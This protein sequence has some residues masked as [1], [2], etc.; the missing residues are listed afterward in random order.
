MHKVAEFGA[1][2]SCIHSINEINM[3]QFEFVPS[4]IVIMLIVIA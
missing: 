3:K 1:S 4:K 2:T